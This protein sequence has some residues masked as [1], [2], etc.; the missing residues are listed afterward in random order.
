MRDSPNRFIA[1]LIGTV[2]LCLA[3]LGFLLTLAPGANPG[4]SPVLLGF[5]RV[6]N[7][8]NAMHLV[9]GAALIVAGQSN[10]RAA[11]TV[12]LAT[13]AFFALMGLVGLFL[14]DGPYNFLALSTGGNALHFAGGAALLGVALAAERGRSPA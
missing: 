2:T 14:I 12:N 9:V 10:A 3:I 8:Q 7:L 1:V 6:N 4:E 11:R 13:G 5:V